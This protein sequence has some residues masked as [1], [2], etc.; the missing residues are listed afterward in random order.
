[1]PLLECLT[2]T[3]CYF[4]II[5]F[6]FEENSSK[7]VW[8]CPLLQP[9]T[10]IFYLLHRQR[11]DIVQHDFIYKS[12]QFH[13]ESPIT[14]SCLLRINPT[15]ILGHGAVLELWVFYVA[16]SLRWPYKPL[17]YRL[18]HARHTLLS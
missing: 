12:D 10:N 17:V 9:L 13:F 18:E 2:V 3:N 4:R 1:S 15:K 8:A 14:A 11:G 6:N 5:H 16:A 7:V